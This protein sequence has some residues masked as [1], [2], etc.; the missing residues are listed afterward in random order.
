MNELELRIAAL[1]LLELERLAI[2][3]PEALV[4]LEVHIKAPMRQEIEAGER[5]VRT[6]ALQLID[7]ARRRF[8]EFATGQHLKL[9]N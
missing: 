1:E 6:H 3:P 4:Q 2:M 8:D 9:E 5:A 7:D